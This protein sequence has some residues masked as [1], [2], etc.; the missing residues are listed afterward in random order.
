MHAFDENAALVR[1]LEPC[2]A[3][4]GPD[5]EQ[6]AS[7][8]GAARSGGHLDGHRSVP[9]LEFAEDL[10]DVE[11]LDAVGERV[12][13]GGEFTRRGGGAGR[14][15]AFPDGRNTQSTNCFSSVSICCCRVHSSAGMCAGG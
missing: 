7:E 4:P 9:G 11:L 13:R 2:R 15:D 5:R 6:L 8:D 10:I 12:E 1:P 3:R 14:H